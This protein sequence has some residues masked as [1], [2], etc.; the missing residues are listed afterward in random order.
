MAFRHN[1]AI[2]SSAVISMLALVAC[3]P[4]FNTLK[5]AAKDAKMKG[6]KPVGPALPGVPTNPTNPINPLPGGGSQPAGASCSAVTSSSIQLLNDMAVTTKP[7]GGATAQIQLLYNNDLMNITADA[8]GT[9]LSSGTVAV[10]VTSGTPAAGG[11]PAQQ[12]GTVWQARCR[13]EQCTSMQVLVFFQSPTS[14]MVLALEGASAQAV[15]P[16][17]PAAEQP[18]VLTDGS[19]VQVSATRIASD[20]SQ[21]Q[22][23][24]LPKPV[25]SFF[26]ECRT[27]FQR[28]DGLSP[29][30]RNDE[31]DWLSSRDA[32]R[33]FV[34]V[35]QQHRPCNR[36]GNADARAHREV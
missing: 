10:A 17:P 33:F 9:N 23:I 31:L 21:T 34:V 13:D 3:Q 30:G 25:E 19:V 1:F 32:E 26:A 7:E 6:P 4:S 36:L 16:A 5:P 22:A 2:V 11:T 15:K 18:P 29:P 24:P 20:S 35:A 27:R 8:G 12:Y 28:L 14:A